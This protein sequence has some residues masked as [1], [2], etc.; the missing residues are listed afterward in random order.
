MKVSDAVQTPLS[1]VDLSKC[2]DK[3]LTLVVAEV[4]FYAKEPLQFK[5]A[6]RIFQMESCLKGGGVTF[7]KNEDAKVLNLDGFLDTY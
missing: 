3:T 7:L 2:D 1:N 4:K 6:R 5:I